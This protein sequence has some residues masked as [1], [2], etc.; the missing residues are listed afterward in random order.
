MIGIG[1]HAGVS[2]AEYLALDAIGSTHLS[3]LDVSPLYYQH[4]RKLNER[5]TEST[6]LGTAVHTAVLE[7]ETFKSRYVSEPDLDEIGGAKP[8][9]TKA[10][11]E[12]VAV[13]E[14]SGREVM[15]NDVSGKV[16]AMA[17]AVHAHPLAAKLLR[18]ATEREL[19]MLWDQG[20]GR[21]DGSIGTRLCRGRADAIG[22]G[23]LV[24]LKTTRSLAR[25]SPFELT[26]FAYHRQQA[27]YR[28]GSAALGLKVQHVFVIAVES[29]APFDV[30]V[31]E[32]DED[33]LSVGEN[34]CTELLNRLAEC[35]ASRTWPGMFPELQKGTLTDYVIAEAALADLEVA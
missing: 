4:M 11:K 32:M 28:A 26:K 8:R 10:Y 1:I 9:A 2:M 20:F 3:W 29:V 33:S 22:G 16:W 12:A 30:G 23:V 19:T 7:P 24:D 25:F 6:S 15:R 18:I 13:L 34:E 5:D 31:F 27:L 17:Q 35:E 14:A 21:P